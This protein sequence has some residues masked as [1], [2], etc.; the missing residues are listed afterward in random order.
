M[1]SRPHVLALLLLLW[2]PLVGS[3]RAVGQAGNTP[4]EPAE[5][6]LG[7]SA[8]DL[9]G[10]WRFEV[11]DNPL[12]AQP[13]FN[14]G[15]WERVSLRSPED[16]PNPELG[17]SLPIPG[18]T[19]LGH[20]QTAGYAWY[21]LR[22]QVQGTSK[23]LAIKMPDDFDD[24]Y[25][26]FVNGE[27]VGEFGRFGT[28]RVKAYATQ[29]RGFKLPNTIRNGPMVIA[30]RVWMASETRF[31]APDAGGL[32]GPPMLGLAST[33]ATQVRMDWESTAHRLGT[34][35]VEDLVLLLALIVAVAH[36]WLDREDR[37]YRWLGLVALATLLGNVILQASNYTTTF[38]Q[39]EAAVSRDVF[40][41]PLRI[42]VWV[43]FW[44][45]W[46]RLGPVRRLQRTV[47]T[48]AGVLAIGTAMMRPPLLGQVVPVSAATILVPLLLVAKLGL[49]V[50]LLWITFRGIREDRAEGWLTLPA[51]LFAILA[52][53]Q[54]ELRLL[55]V[56]IFFTPYHYRLSL[57][58]ISTVVSL[59]L[60]TVM[61][62]RR[63]LLAERCR[64]QYG[65]EV[66]QAAELQR[67]I[68]PTTVPQV[69]G[70][71]IQSEYRPSLQVGGDFFQ[72]IPD[73]SDGSVLVVVGDVTGKG[74]RA[75]M[76]VALMVGA[77]DLSVKD[78]AKP[79]LLLER[80]NDHLYERGYASATCLAMRI[81]DDGSVAIANAGHMPPYWNC[82]E[83]TMEGS[84]PLG[85]LPGARYETVSFQLAERDTLV[86]MTDGV[87]EAQDRDG[88]LFGFDRLNALV[89]GDAS[90]AQIAEAAQHFGQEDDILVLRVERTRIHSAV[91][92]AAA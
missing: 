92:T 50:L 22:L 16:V 18:W 45:A 60:I 11:G 72:V 33:I 86:L 38:S 76:L 41:A 13:G 37:A 7:S 44:A 83:L 65:I 43:L 89:A 39:T 36:F 70:L 1:A 40:L 2:L 91:E 14:D 80:L 20:P 35:F 77:I 78:E 73:V 17:K 29:P 56:S 67:V 31:V 47:W 52:N 55:H 4:S 46:F 3:G 54:N 27:M 5:V 28:A 63:F 58:Q 69:P 79:G 74:L 19:A 21:R 15:G 12:W 51:I 49:A 75:G 85:M 59:L 34:G 61:A 87:V 57:G 64:V 24:A 8:V 68:V 32:H 53:Y 81:T 9:F 71:L 26:L 6:T 62:S 48:L 90:A 42:A 25:Q 10:P 88:N 84:L 82:E 66:E 30:I 23:P